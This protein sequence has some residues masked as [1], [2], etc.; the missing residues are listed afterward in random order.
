MQVNRQDMD[1][2][3]STV[4]LGRGSTPGPAHVFHG[5][6][7]RRRLAASDDHTEDLGLSRVAMGTVVHLALSAHGREAARPLDA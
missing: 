3:G 1:R 6:K 5:F 4:H 2:A 7:K